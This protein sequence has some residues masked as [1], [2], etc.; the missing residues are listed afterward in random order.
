M[1]AGTS[2]TNPTHSANSRSFLFNNL[3]GRGGFQRA[4]AGDVAEIASIFAPRTSGN[5][6][7]W[8]TWVPSTATWV[9]RSAHRVRDVTDE[10]DL[11]ARA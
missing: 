3:A 10:L 9:H 6:R 7:I 1:R 4:I 5:R 11:V 2:G 8:A